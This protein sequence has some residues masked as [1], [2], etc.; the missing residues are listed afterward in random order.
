MPHYKIAQWLEAKGYAEDSSIGCKELEVDY[1][2]VRL[3]VDREYYLCLPPKK[4]T[5]DQLSTLEDILSRYM[6]DSW[7]TF[8]VTNQDGS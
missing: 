2:C 8:T 1:N 5:W 7:G 3:N 6:Y 4:L